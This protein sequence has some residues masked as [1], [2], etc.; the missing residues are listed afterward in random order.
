MAKAQP[1]QAPARAKRDVYVVAGPLKDN[2]QTTITVVI[3]PKTSFRSAREFA[4]N[5]L[6]EI[7]R[8]K[9][10]TVVSK[11][12]VMLASRIGAVEAQIKARMQ[13]TWAEPFMTMLFV[14]RGAESY[15]LTLIEPG[16]TQPGY[17]SESH[18]ALLSFSPPQRLAWPQAPSPPPSPSPMQPR[19]RSN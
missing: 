9:S 10:L 6:R 19:P 14:V 8:H 7:G 16:R 13:V 1:S 15:H 3:D 12:D 17:S 4:D 11:T 5:C 18:A 2:A